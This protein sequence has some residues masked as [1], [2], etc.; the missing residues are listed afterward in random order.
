[1]NLNCV[2]GETLLNKEVQNLGALVSLKLNNLSCF[3]VFYECAVASEFLLEGFQELL[4]IILLGQAL[5]SRESL[6]SVSLLNTDVDVVLLGPNVLC[7]ADRVSLVCEG[8]ESS[9][10]LHV[11]ATN[12]GSD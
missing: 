2:L 7:G 8:V 10:V 12:V 4:G 1:V 11:H 3:F 5:Q 9:K 6:P